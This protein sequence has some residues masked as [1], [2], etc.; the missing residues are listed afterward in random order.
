MKN[1]VRAII[2]QESK[3]LLI[4]R[5][6]PEMVYW[7]IPGGGTQENETMETALQ[8]ECLEELGLKIKV[9]ELV[10][11]MNS[12][13][14]ETIGQREFFYLCTIIGG[15]LG[16]GSGP[17]YKQ[18]TNYVGQYVIEWIDIKN[19]PSCDLKPEEIK[20]FIYEKYLK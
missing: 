16:S 8:R 19:L 12:E 14:E 18:D 20:N 4:K 6:K 1:R 7:V 17:E 15:V 13:K 11:E 5:V 3:V 10:F 9:G 2:I